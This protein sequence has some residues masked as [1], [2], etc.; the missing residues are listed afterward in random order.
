MGPAITLVCGLFACG[1]KTAGSSRAT[2]ALR[3]DKFILDFQ[4]APEPVRASIS[5][6]HRHRLRCDL[7]PAFLS[8][9]DW[10]GIWGSIY[11]WSALL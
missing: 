8:R 1:G 10:A 5:K 11:A 9:R 4:T 3:N 6:L 7:R 2:T